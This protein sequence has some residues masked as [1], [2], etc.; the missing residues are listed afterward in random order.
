M[1]VGDSMNRNQYE[2][3][4]CLL[5]EGLQDKRRMFETHGYKITK[6]RGYFVF[7]FKVIKK[8]CNDMSSAG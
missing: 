6:G 1:L 7:K 8:T 2:S 4:L 3:I 5:R